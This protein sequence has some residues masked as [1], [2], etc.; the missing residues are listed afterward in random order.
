MVFVRVYLFQDF[1]DL[2][3][4]RQSNTTSVQVELHDFYLDLPWHFMHTL[5]FV[6]IS[7]G[8]CHSLRCKPA[9]ELHF[10]DPERLTL[11]EVSDIKQRK[12]PNWVEHTI[13]VHYDLTRLLSS[14]HFNIIIF[15]EIKTYYLNKNNIE[16]RV[17]CT[18]EYQVESFQKSISLEYIQLPPL[19]VI[20]PG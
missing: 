3:Q 20:T 15:F 1:H 19:T 6:N 14:F 16:A 2:L 5:A 11:W 4:P 10:S 12:R 17:W 7:Y 8:E 13:W 9:Q 18:V